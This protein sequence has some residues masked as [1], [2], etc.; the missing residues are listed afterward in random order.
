MLSKLIDKLS[1]D[2]IG[3][4][5]FA[6]RAYLQMPLTGDHGAAKMYLSS[7]ST[8]AVPTKGTVIAEALKMCYGAFNPKEKKYKSVVLIS[9]GEDHDEGALKMSSQMAADGII[10]NTVGIGSPEGST[11]IDAAT[12]EVKKDEQGNEVITKL[13]EAELTNIAAKGN[14]TYQLYN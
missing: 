3:I 4:V 14:G 1:N 13:N 7:A 8:E 9:D 12:N 11:I 6:G 2:R 5:I 10:I